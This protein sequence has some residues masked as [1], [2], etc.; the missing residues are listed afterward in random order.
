MKHETVAEFLRRGKKINMI[1]RGQSALA[2]VAKLPK[3]I[4]LGQQRSNK[5]SG[6]R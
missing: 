1:P 5:K 2:P 4:I 6:K 3:H